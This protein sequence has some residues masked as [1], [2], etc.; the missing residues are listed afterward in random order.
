LL[1]GHPKKNWGYIPGIKRESF[2]E[3]ER[4]EKKSHETISLN[5][6]II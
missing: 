3:T 2:D 1:P 6:A 4:D 5:V